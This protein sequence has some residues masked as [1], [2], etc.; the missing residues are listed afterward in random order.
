[1]NSFVTTDCFF[2]VKMTS[3]CLNPNLVA[4]FWFIKT[5]SFFGSSTSSYPCFL[6]LTYTF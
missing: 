4:N 2:F 5:L 1:M 6:L 3:F